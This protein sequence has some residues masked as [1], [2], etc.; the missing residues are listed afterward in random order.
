MMR[1]SHDRAIVI[2]LECGHAYSESTCRY[3]VQEFVASAI[4][5]HLVR[6]GVWCKECHAQCQPLR[7][8]GTCRTL[9]G[10]TQKQKQEATVILKRVRA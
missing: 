3:R 6:R 10:P 5:G 7:Y 2:G 8:L 4:V 1:S 9:T